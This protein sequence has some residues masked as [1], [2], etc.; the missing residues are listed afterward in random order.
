MG[1]ILKNMARAATTSDAFNAV[2]R[3]TAADIL[4]FFGA[5]GEGPSA[6]IV[7]C[8]GAGAA[9]SFEAP[10]RVLKDVGLCGFSK[11]GPAN[12]YTG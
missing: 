3:T 9:V 7:R 8:V 11:G 4:N 10:E 5:A 12:A 6:E 1:I 2:A